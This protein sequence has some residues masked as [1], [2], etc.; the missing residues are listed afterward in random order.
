MG[1]SDSHIER[2][3]GGMRESRPVKLTAAA[4]APVLASLWAPESAPQ[5]QLPEPG[6]WPLAR[7]S[8]LAVAPTR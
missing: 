8:P 5:A 7:V 1:G 6:S 4:L 2:T 3:V